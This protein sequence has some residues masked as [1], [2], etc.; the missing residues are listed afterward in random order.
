MRIQALRE[1][2]A[3]TQANH[4]PQTLG[5]YGYK[6]GSDYFLYNW[7]AVTQN[8]PPGDRKAIMA[9]LRAIFAINI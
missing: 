6:G 4:L 5:T 1:S 3:L 8:I 7:E 9:L 2:S